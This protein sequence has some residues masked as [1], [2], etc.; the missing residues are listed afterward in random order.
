MTSD[1]V[2][3]CKGP[4]LQA[5]KDW[6]KDVTAIDHVILVGGSTRMPMIQELV[7]SSPAARSPTRA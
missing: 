5:I 7:K 2:D 1:L 4:F 3:A 6:G